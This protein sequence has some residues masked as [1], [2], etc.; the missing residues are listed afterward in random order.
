MKYTIL[1]SLTCIGVC[2]LCLLLLSRNTDLQSVGN[3]YI[4]K[5]DSLQV[6]LNVIKQQKQLLTDSIHKLTAGIEKEDEEYTEL[7]T[8]LQTGKEK[9]TK[10]QY[11]Y[12]TLNLYQDYPADSICSFFG[13]RFGPGQH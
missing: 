3:S 5:M 11:Q 12:E 4:K 1:L 2:V 13:T 6:Q 7:R 10:I 9:L 8:T